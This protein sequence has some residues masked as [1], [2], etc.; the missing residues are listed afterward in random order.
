MNSGLYKSLIESELLISHEEVDIGYALSNNAYKIIKPELIT[1]ISYPYEWCFDQLKDAALTTLKIQKKSLDFGM[2]LKDCS[3]YNIQF[4]KGKSIFIDTLSFEKYQEGCPWN[5]YRQ[6]CQH[7]LAPLAL[8]SYKDIRLN[9]L[10]RIYIDGIPLNLSSKLLPFSSYF[11]FSLFSHIHLHAQCQKYFAYKPIKKRSRRKIS[12]IALLG[13]VESLESCVKNL[14]WRPKKTEW[15]NYYDNTNYSCDSFNHKKQL[16]AEFFDKIN[17][18]IVWDLGA[19]I[20]SFSRIAANKGTQVISVD[21]DPVCIENN[22]L[23]NKKKGETNILPLL[24]DLTNPSSSIGWENQE[25]ISFIE[26]GPADTV[27]ALA[28][29]HHL[30]IVNNLPLNIIAKFFNGICNSLIIEFVPKCDSQVQRLLSTRED[31][32]PGYTQTAFEN[33]FSKFF[34]KKDSSK[35][36]DTK[37]ILYLMVKKNNNP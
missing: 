13:L 31:I 27:L 19:N 5:A 36:R 2:S 7:F 20:G 24:L 37:R 10:L 17:P 23:E 14:K 33:E 8:M 3:A 6:F 18:K 32:F 29:I 28:L 22:Y 9:Q 26:R 11:V 1:F 15:C 35:I 21:N 12:Q 30:A 34:I 4:K 25:R 16:V